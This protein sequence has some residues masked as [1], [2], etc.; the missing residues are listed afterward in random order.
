MISI[1]RISRAAARSSVLWGAL[2]TVAFYVGLQQLQ[3]WVN[4]IVLRYV[5][6]RW[7][8]YACVSL[9][10]VGI[11]AIVI[12]AVDLSQGWYYFYRLNLGPVDAR[13][14]DAK[15]LIRTLDGQ[16]TLCRSTCLHRRLRDALEFVLKRK[17]GDSLDGHL[18]YLADIDTARMNTSYGTPRF[19][20]WAIPAVGS[21][22][23]V[24]AIAIAIGQLSTPEPAASID[25]AQAA[26]TM[27]NSVTASLALAF[28]TLG[29]ALGLSIVLMLAKFGCE[30][31]ES[32][33]LDA[34][35]ERSEREL[36]ERVG[37]L[38]AASSESSSDQMRFLAE[39]LRELTEKIAANSAMSATAPASSGGITN[40]QIESIVSRAVASAVTGQPTVTIGSSGQL[41]DMS[42]VQEALKQIAGFFSIQQAEHEQESEI[43]Q[44]LSEIIR[45]GNSGWK[46]RKQ[47]DSV[48]GSLVGLWNSLSD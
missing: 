4:P 35:E 16:S 10:F 2:A 31:A 14:S 13:T 15:S 38:T 47:G 25:A 9:F 48:T 19:L 7:E 34:V 43:V 6:G 24:L 21:L 1:E 27:L 40:D 29:L 8:A 46:P 32:H 33:L 5:A 3:E 37:G 42:Q 30:Q 36:A 17:G 18:R 20:C 26:P 39:R 11:A 28:D 22:G 12:K 23:T 45:E 41:T 44:Q